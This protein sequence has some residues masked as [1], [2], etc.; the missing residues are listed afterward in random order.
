MERNVLL[1]SVFI[2]LG[3]VA[4]LSGYLLMSE[5]RQNFAKQNLGGQA[6]LLTDRFSNKVEAGLSEDSAPNTLPLSSRKFTTFVQPFTDSKKIVAVASNGNIV[7]I[8]TA[9]LTEKV[10]YAD[11]TSVVEATLSPAGNAVIFSFYGTA[12]DKKWV[13][14]NMKTRKSSKIEG[15]LKSAAFS[16]DGSQTVYL[17][18]NDNEGELLIA[19]DGKIIKRALK[20]RIGAATVS[21]PSENIIS[22]IS[23]D[24]DGSG[25]LFVLSLDSALNKVL[26][27][28]HNL[29]VKW[30]P[31]GEK[32]IFSTK[33]AAVPTQ[34]FYKDIKN[35][36]AITALGVDTNAS[37]CVWTNEEN[38]ICGITDK[39]QVKDGFYKI[40]LIDGSKTL[41]ATK[42]DLVATPDI[43]LLVK[44]MSINR[45]GDTL[46]VLNDIDSKL[47][48]L[49]IK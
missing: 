32:I 22:I 24:K 2:T 7:E 23:Y 5:T 44:E 46:F 20:T 41:A 9:D 4:F 6:G 27:Y 28:Q 8:N 48:V 14:Y 12:N 31:V 36:G 30:S 37:K 19:K 25:D 35:S 26:S 45:S 34:L 39:A 29:E 21:W 1:I 18:N 40:N 47:Y 10:V 33:D 13:Y 43:N 38:I 17:V 49:K 15:D 3:A 16:P 42:S 11:Q